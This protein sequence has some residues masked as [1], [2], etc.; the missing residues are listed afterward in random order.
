[1]SREIWIGIVAAIVIVGGLIGYS[2]WDRITQA[3]TAQ[4]TASDA[5]ADA[6]DDDKIHYQIPDPAPTD[7]PLPALVESDSTFHDALTSLFAAA[8]IESFLISKQ[9][10]QKIVVVVNSLDGEG[11]PVRLWP[12][13]SAPGLPV[14]NTTADGALSLSVDNTKRYTRYVT[15]V[16]AVD[17]QA[18]AKIYLRYYP[19]F[20]QAYIELGF[21]DR[22][23]NDRMISVLN[24][25]LA[26]PAV[27]LPVAL[28][29]PKVLYEYADYEIE[30]RSVGQK[31][32]IR[33]GPENAAIVKAKIKQFRD[34][35]IAQSKL[36]ANTS[37]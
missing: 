27:T 25:L 1:M 4:P 5:I 16:N 14:V 2:Y 18:L 10:I 22:Y 29:R 21:P 34:A 33:L 12:L 36:A 28:T 3:D 7:A 35:V 17:A 6:P 23:F 19:L 9:L 13:T 30:S 24:H 8:P 26:T 20:Q 32:L 37:H 11:V 15:A 31:L